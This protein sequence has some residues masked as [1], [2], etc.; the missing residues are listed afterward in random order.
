MTGRQVSG[1]KRGERWSYSVKA[2]DGESWSEVVRSSEL[3]IPNSLPECQ[4]LALEPTS[5]FSGDVLTCRYDYNDADGDLESGTSI[6]W[7]RNDNMQSGYN[8]QNA[9]PSGV[10]KAGDSWHVIVR[11]SDGIGQG[12][13]VKSNVVY[14]GNVPPVA[15]ELKLTQ[16]TSGNL[17]CSYAYFDTETESGSE[18]RWYRDGAQ[19][20]AYN[21]QKQIANTELH[22][23]ERW[24]FIL[25]VSDGVLY[26]EA[27]PSL[28]LTI[29]NVPPIASNLSIYPP[30]AFRVDKLECRYVYTDADGDAETGSEITWYR[31]NENQS[32][33]KNHREIPST[34]LRRGEEWHYVLKPCDGTDYGA[35]VTSPKVKIGNSPP[36]AKDLV[37][38]PA[39]PTSS[40]TLECGYSYHDA[41]GDAEG[42]TEIRWYRDDLYQSYYKNKS[43]V[44]SLKKGQTWHFTVK[45][46]DGTDYGEVV[47]SSKVTIQ[48]SVPVLS[49][50]RIRQTG[51]KL[52]ASYDYSDADG[53]P[54]SESTIVWYRSGAEAVTGRQVSGVKRG[55]RW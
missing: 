44:A 27:R 11:V 50:V 40:S 16:D 32:G 9:L 8:D 52:E 18:I 34:E 36:I 26:D 48:N 42:L 14:I 35:E 51:D 3:E 23:G 17:V 21:D 47:T 33:Y 55:E 4:N 46:H 54:E 38:T 6:R 49:D 15:S 25:R 10:T 5:A 7:Y 1:V 39:N 45:A 13:Y 31:N 43:K 12:K 37:L 2:S 53:D 19:M 29:G 20:T 22:K 24:H 30:N 41:D 28:I